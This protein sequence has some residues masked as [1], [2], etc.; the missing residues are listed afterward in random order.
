MMAVTYRV[1][2]S[3]VL[4]GVAAQWEKGQLCD[5]KIT[6]EGTTIAA[7]RNILAASSPYFESM[8]LSEFKE[9]KQTKVNL[10]GINPTGLDLVIR[11]I[12]TEQLKLTNKVVP[13]VLSVAHFLQIQNIID[14]CEEH[15][16]SKLSSASCFKF[17]Q[18]FERYSLSKGQNAAN[19]YILKNFVAISKTCDFLDIEKES[20]CDYLEN[21]ELCIQDEI[22]VFRAAQVWIEHDKGRIQHCSEIMKHIRF[23]FIS[24]KVMASEVRKV[25]FMKQDKI[26]MDLL[27]ETYEYQTSIFTQPM[28]RST[29]NKPRGKPSVLIIESGTEKK[30]QD[31]DMLFAITEEENPAWIVQMDDMTSIHKEINL[32]I[33]FARESVSL[34]EYG[35]FLYLLGV[36]SR[37]FLTVTLRYDGNTD[38]WMDL[39]PMPSA[40]A[41][42]CAVARVRETIIVT[43]GRCVTGTDTEFQPNITLTDRTLLYDIPSNKWKPAAKYPECLA[44]AAACEHADIMYVAGGEN[45]SHDIGRKMWS[46]ESKGDVW[47]AKADMKELRRDSFLHSIGDKLLSFDYHFYS[48][49]IFDPEQNLW[50]KI[51]L[52]NDPLFNPTSTFVYNSL[53]YALSEY[54]RRII[55]VTAEGYD[56]LNDKLP[57]KPCTLWTYSALLKLK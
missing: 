27:F 17:L 14:T 38:Q 25:E 5:I 24:P 20:L 2:G 32:G 47:L 15:M 41:V 18:I 45:A 55:T 54:T 56:V 52:D 31:G 26:C 30:T 4:K 19:E 40:A 34:V 10:K 16:I 28:Y 53:V 57:R 36:D 22:E 42:G 21:E 6:A 7:H 51:D 23:A 46:Y 9:S 8:F 48:L 44:Y 1:Q 37:T 13:D 12:Y 11:C 49:E 43:T 33:P 35:N 39:A 3:N 29:I 50:S